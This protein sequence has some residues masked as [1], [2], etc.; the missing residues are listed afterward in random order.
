MTFT[1]FNPIQGPQAAVQQNQ[2]LSLKQGQV[3]HGTIKK[4]YPDQMAEIQVGSSKLFAKLETP[5]KAGDTYFFQV[6][7]MNPQTELKV[8]T[9]PMQRSLAT[10]QQLTQL[11]D[12]LNLPKTPEMQ[13]I[14]AQFVKNQLP[15][16]KENLLSAE[17]WLKSLTESAT[18]Q[19]A[20]Q[21]IQKMAEMKM[22]FSNE[23]F[24]GFL[25][26][27]KINGMSSAMTNLANV[28]AQD[29]NIEPTVKSNIL[30]Q[31]Q[32]I[33]KPLAEETGGSILSNAAKIL[34]NP[35]E[36]PQQ[37]MQ[38][39]QLLKETGI[40]PKHAT[41][42]SWQNESFQQQKNMPATSLQAQ[43]NAAEE[44]W[45]TQSS[46]QQRYIET[47]K[48]T[49]GGMVQ[50]IMAAK[51][52]DAQ[53]KINQLRTWVASQESFSV[54]QKSS[55]E[56][57][58]NRFE[59]LPKNPATMELFAKQLHGQLV[60]AFSD[61]PSQQTANLAF[62]QSNHEQLLSLLKPEAGN[63]SSALVNLA[64]LTAESNIPEV[65]AISARAEQQVLS[66]IDGKTMEQALKTILKGLGLSYEATLNNKTTDIGELAHSLKP[67]LLSLLQDSQTSAVLRD[68]AENVV[69]R[70]N[71]MQF[72]SGENGPQHQLVMQI[73]LQFLGKQTEATVQWN[74]RMKDNG[75]IDSNYARILFYLNMEALKET[76]V[77]MQVQNRIVTITLYND[78]PEL[79]LLTE[80]LREPLKQG[81]SEKSYQLSGLFVKPFE[82]TTHQQPISH[83][84]ENKFE[85]KNGVDFRI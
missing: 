50:E 58:I 53:Q 46:E 85:S 39:L 19:E 1:S 60:K 48:Q 27:S 28:L 38:M 49:A 4:L 14:V 68:A 74:G 78:Q 43:Q 32:L 70:L 7:S 84:K 21:A 30:Q 73:P 54:E 56:Q 35:T 62:S 12:N 59:A 26:G 72:N 6:T 18:K 11:L 37:K 20:L 79:E 23:V 44:A 61:A 29:V 66:A 80:P 82:T 77:D 55:L 3:L 65:H 75:K 57:L 69:A 71:G 40:L 45:K 8:V 51:P 5:L 63:N 67:Q 10:T 9:G 2:P 33:S 81:L 34:S 24:K 13:Q 41:I 31:L 25:Y 52:S 83:L 22:P 42:E 76:M 16:L 17:G 15:L 47:G 36:A 64:K